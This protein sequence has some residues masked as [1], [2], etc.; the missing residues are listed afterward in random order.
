[1]DLF[2]TAD[3]NIRYQQN[4]TRRTIGILELSTNNLHRITA[5]AELIVGVITRMPP[6]DF[7]LLEIP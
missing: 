5:A 2:I 1:Y 6:R 7:Q 4:L 3:Q